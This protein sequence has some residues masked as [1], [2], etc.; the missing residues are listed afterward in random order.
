MTLDQMPNEL[1]MSTLVTA[2][3]QAL[4][5]ELPREEN[6]PMDDNDLVSVTLTRQEWENIVIASI[7]TT[8]EERVHG[9]GEDPTAAKIRSQIAGTAAS[10][11]E[12]R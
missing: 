2:Q 7:Q 11:Q 9:E 4:L 10:Q 5:R 6:A 3:N 8:W 1:R 12:E